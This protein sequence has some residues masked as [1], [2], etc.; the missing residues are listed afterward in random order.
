MRHASPAAAVAVGLAA[1]AIGWF[2]PL[3]AISLLAFLLIEVFV[4]GV[5]GSARLG[6]EVPSGAE[7]HL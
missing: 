3:L 7:T 5:S 4:G 6:T 1:I 2:L